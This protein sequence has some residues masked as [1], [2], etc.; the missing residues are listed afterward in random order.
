MA[1]LNIRIDDA[2][3]HQ[4]EQVFSEL[5]LSMSAATTIFFKQVVRHN[6]IPFELKVDP[7]YNDYN[8]KRLLE[9]KERMLKSGGV[10]HNLIEDSDD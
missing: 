1:N 3:K 8:Q 6:G 10:E 5:G 9:A 4:A 2:L 7:F